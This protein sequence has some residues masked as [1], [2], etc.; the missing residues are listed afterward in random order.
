MMTKMRAAAVFCTALYLS[1][2]VT[3]GTSD[4]SGKFIVQY[5]TLKL[6]EQSEQ[7]TGPGVLETVADIRARVVNDEEVRYVDLRPRLMEQLRY[8]TL[9]PS[10]QLLLMELF[11]RLMG[12]VEVGMDI[13]FIGDEDRVRISTFLDWVE[14]AARMAR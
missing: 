6:I 14:Q 5:S 2:C 7:F 3:S 9:A 8:D 1:G 13:E 4:S 11:D 12:D 10:D